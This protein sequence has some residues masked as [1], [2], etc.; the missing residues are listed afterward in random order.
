MPQALPTNK[1]KHKQNPNNNEVTKGNQNYHHSIAKQS[2]NVNNNGVQVGL[3]LGFHGLI[4]WGWFGCIAEIG[5]VFNAN[6]A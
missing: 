1:N 5:E 6:R 4:L 3:D 2:K